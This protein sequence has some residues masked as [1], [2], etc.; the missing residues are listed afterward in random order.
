MPMIHSTCRVCGGFFYTSK[1]GIRELCDR[2][3]KAELIRT[4]EY[5]NTAK[6]VLDEI[7][8]GP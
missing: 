7:K 4:I 6:I 2:H 1:K 3:F 5:K 8:V